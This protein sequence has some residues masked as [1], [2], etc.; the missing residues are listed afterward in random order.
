[1]IVVSLFSGTSKSRLSLF[2]ATMAR[3]R[4]PCN[5]VLVLL[6]QEA[7]RLDLSYLGNKKVLGGNR[8]ALS[9]CSRATEYVFAGEM[10][11][12]CFSVLF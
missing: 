3:F 1:M 6:S 11:G 4:W 10:S 12:A 7:R 2:I 8:F 5:V 9:S